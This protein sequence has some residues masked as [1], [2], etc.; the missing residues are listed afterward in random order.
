MKDKPWSVDWGRFKDVWENLLR[1]A[2]RE[3]VFYGDKGVSVPLSF[4]V[5]RKLKVL[6]VVRPVA[7]GIKTHI[8]SLI[9]HLDPEKYQV[10]VAGPENSVIEDLKNKNVITYLV[11][12]G[13][14]L[15]FIR[16]IKAILHLRNIIKDEGIFMVHAHSY[17]AALLGGLA[18]RWAKAP[19]TVFTLHNFIVE[20]GAG[21]FKHL[22]Y[23]VTERFLPSM[24]DRV[25]TVSKALRRRVI[26]KGKA[27]NSKVT[28]IHNG[29]SL[30]S[31]VSFSSRRV[32]ALKHQLS[33]PSKA[34]LVVTV[35]R[36]APQKGVKFL[37]TAATHVLREV[38]NAQFLIVGDGPLKKDL[39]I[40][41]EKSGVR[42][43]IFFTGFRDDVRDILAACDIF[44]LPSLTEGLPLTVLE[45]MAAGKPV[46]ATAVGGI[47]EVVLDRETGF[48]VP[49]RKPMPLAKA[50]SFLLL[51]K[52]VAIQMGMAGRRRAE[53]EFNLRRTIG[54]TE[55]VYDELIEGWEEKK[56]EHLE[57]A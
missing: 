33:L 30:R 29:I 56:R 32:T 8:L 35:A 47:P 57:E 39:E 13:E 44:V 52:E 45:A 10:Y 48:L 28:M 7:G 23:D 55:K 34:P 21:R 18:A 40:M 16:D 51:N 17:K 24:A 42:R 46:V 3:E 53:E 26:D 14:G 43:K 41:V 9:E 31:A 50:I 36:L 4:S 27:E 20:E 25:I 1:R 19:L 2:T 15:R 11:D 12:V 49:P 37:L 54:E 38:P 22:F 5:E 6:Y